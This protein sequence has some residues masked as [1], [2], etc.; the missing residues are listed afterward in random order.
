MNTW[1]PGAVR[2][3]TLLPPQTGDVITLREED[4]VW[5]SQRES[6]KDLSA[7]RNRR[8]PFSPTIY[9]GTGRPRVPVDAKGVAI[10]L[11]A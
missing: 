8:L 4:G 1:M 2:M 5:L 3:P 7:G 6:S 9:D 10:D 11:F